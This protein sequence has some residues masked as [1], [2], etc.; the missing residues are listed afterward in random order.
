MDTEKERENMKILLR[1]LLLALITVVGIC[2]AASSCCHKIYENMEQ[3]HVDSVRVEIR[4]RIVHDTT[5]FEIPVEIERIVVK[6]DSSTLENTYAKSTAFVDGDGN[7]H[8]SLE[9][10]PQTIDVPFT[11]SVSDTTTVH[12]TETAQKETI[13]KEVEREFTWWE[14]VRLR[15]FWWL[16]GAVVIL[17]GWTFRKQIIKLIGKV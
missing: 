13:V 11:V 16:A 12:A 15:A 4:D 2:F 9:T 3:S 8:H 1:F 6:Q 17:L 10:K 5:T 14:K 7:L